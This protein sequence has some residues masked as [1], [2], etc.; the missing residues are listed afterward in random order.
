LAHRRGGDKNPASVGRRANFHEPYRD[1]AV[2]SR[3][4]P[5]D[6]GFY[7]HLDRLV[8]PIVL[9]LAVGANATEHS[10]M[11]TRLREA[12]ASVC[13]DR[14]G[15]ARA[16]ADRLGAVLIE[17]TDTD[18]PR[19]NR[20]VQRIFRY[21]SGD[22]IRLRIMYRDGALSFLSAV[23]RGPA[24]GTAIRPKM[25][26]AA[27]PSCEIMQL[28]RITYDAKDR[29]ETLLILPT[30]LGNT[31]RRIPLNPAV[32][33]GVDPGGVTV[34]LVDSGI[35]YRLPMFANSL[36]RDGA[37]RAL[38]YDYWDMDDRPY[39]IDAAGSPFFPRHHGTRVASVLLRAAPAIRLI[40]YRYPRPDLRRMRALIADADANGA[41]VVALPMGSNEPKDWQ[42]FAAA[43][44]ARPHMLFVISAGNDER[45]IDRHPIYPAA[46][47]LDNAIVV[48]SGLDDGRLAPGSNWGRRGVDLVVPAEDVAVV[49]HLGAAALGSGSSYA[50]PLV[51]ALAA[52]L[53]ARHPKW[54]AVE[55]K[56]AI[57]ARARLLPGGGGRGVRH[58]WI[59][60]SRTGE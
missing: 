46:L 40:P 47:G 21:P 25:M 52:R 9:F 26:A 54:A 53:A 43:A 57:I 8:L 2:Q 55:L 6:E 18:L 7:M 5:V 56:R 29:A 22:T 27:Q 13:D 38:G 36:A 3:G 33:D 31:E 32:P 58:G 16:I 50:V 24:R 59:G 51:A 15:S 41:R 12:V 20:Q 39:D 49:D 48:T 28:R 17:N 37:G 44:R 60:V 34:A 10:K 30:A 19:G 23:L 35:N 4:H 1:G 14:G 11:E 45:D 42:A